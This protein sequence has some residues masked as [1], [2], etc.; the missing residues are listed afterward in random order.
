MKEGLDLL[1]ISRRRQKRW[2]KKRKKMTF[3][4]NF[5]SNPNKTCAKIWKDLCLADFDEGRVDISKDTVDHFLLALFF[6]RHNDTEDDRTNRFDV[7][8]NV[9]R[10]MAWYFMDKIRAHK[11][12][13]I[14]WDEARYS[15]NKNH[16][17][18]CTCI[19]GRGPKTMV[20][21][22]P[23]KRMRRFQRDSLTV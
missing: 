20:N 11:H 23:S 17:S 14:V 16:C 10:D 5:G 7:C 6:L 19:I 21:I 8:E 9:I 22:A 13:K 2:G 15:K 18:L 12:L 1:A 3:T 4:L